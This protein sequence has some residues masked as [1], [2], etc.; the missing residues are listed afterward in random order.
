MDSKLTDT[1]EAI[2]LFLSDNEILNTVIDSVFASIDKDHSGSIE[3]SEITGF[4]DKINKQMELNMSSNKDLISEVFK[5][6]D[7]DH[8][9]AIDKIE[10]GNFLRTLLRH[11]KQKLLEKM[12]KSIVKI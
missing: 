4:I 1:L 9:K 5:E 2:E 7:K 3:E 8:S 11:Q 6:M 10:L 12:K